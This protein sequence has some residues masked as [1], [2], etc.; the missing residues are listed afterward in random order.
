MLHTAPPFGR[1]LGYTRADNVPIVVATVVE[2]PGKFV[3]MHLRA[4]VFD[5]RT[6]MLFKSDELQERYLPMALPA[7]P[8]LQ[9]RLHDNTQYQAVALAIQGDHAHEQ[10]AAPL[11]DVVLAGR[12]FQYSELT[13]QLSKFTKQFEQVAQDVS[14]QLG[15]SP[16][17]MAV[18]A[19]AAPAQVVSAATV[20]AGMSSAMVGCVVLRGNRCV[21]VR[22]LT[23]V[24]QGLRIPAVVQREGESGAECAIRSVTELCEV[25]ATEIDI[26]RAVPPVR[27]YPADG[28]GPVLLY[29]A[30]AT[31]GPPPGPLEDADIEDEEDLYDWFTFMRAAERLED[32]AMDALRT[33]ACA[34]AAAA[35]CRQIP[36]KWGGVFGQEWLDAGMAPRAVLVNNLETPVAAVAAPAIQADAEA[37]SE[38]AGV[39]GALKAM[40]RKDGDKLPVTVLSG[41]LGAGK[42]TLMQHILS[43]RH[44]LK[45]AVI[46]NDMGD[47]NIDAALIDRGEAS[48]KRGEERMVEL[49]NGCICCTLREDLFKEIGEVSACPFAGLPLLR[50]AVYCTR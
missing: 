1:T 14:K 40:G 22:S 13:F 43:N 18:T 46:V 16:I 24:W 11:E 38:M 49:S 29:A 34:L 39:E 2:L 21:L 20:A 42:T 10:W 31:D 48:L 28:S 25:D 37:K 30:Y 33:L 7:L 8:A 32:P 5:G 47:V 17:E 19:A 44:G 6:T 3:N 4:P 9:C 12:H 15:D 41:F 35:R 27:L 50:C 26:L 45:V 36:N 23:G